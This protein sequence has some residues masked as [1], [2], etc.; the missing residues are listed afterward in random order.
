LAIRNVGLNNG[1]SINQIVERIEKQFDSI[2][3]LYPKVRQ[4]KGH[5]PI[6]VKV[7]GSMSDLIMGNSKEKADTYGQ[8][9]DT[10]AEIVKE[11]SYN[12]VLT[13]GGGSF[14]DFTNQVSAA[15]E[16]SQVQQ[17]KMARMSYTQHA[18]TLADML[19]NRGVDA[20]KIDRT[21]L[22][23]M[24][25]T[26]TLSGS[27]LPYVPI[28]LSIPKDYPRT[29]YTAVPEQSDKLALALANLLGVSNP[30]FL[31]DTDG[32]H[33]WDP[34]LNEDEARKI[35][36]ETNVMVAGNPQ[37]KR[38]YAPDIPKRI[39][40][41]AIT[42]TGVT[43]EHVV[44]DNALDVLNNSLRVASIQVVDGKNPQ[45]ISRAI[46]GEPVGSYILR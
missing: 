2:I 24:V 30:I 37:I 6:I 29:P 4:K 10:L 8:M 19:K 35:I 33:F 11:N 42:K 25:Q 12:L 32:I 40:R 27:A 23:Q 31:K 46:R 14:R 45:A 34:N 7:G 3:N 39:S 17:K 41:Y 9:V 20:K 1:E 13:V 26:T 18:E 28:V 22:L 5:Q 21:D 43:N 36:P 38:I 15:T 16:I 44:E